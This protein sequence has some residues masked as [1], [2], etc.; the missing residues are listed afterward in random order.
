[1]KNRWKLLIVYLLCVISPV[2]AGKADIS[3]ILEER[4]GL[5]ANDLG[6]LVWDGET[7]W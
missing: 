6:D 5:G 3:A 7:I 2:W 1:M 4:A